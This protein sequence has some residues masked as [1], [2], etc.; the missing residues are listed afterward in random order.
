M[1]VK[2]PLVG[3]S[4]RYGHG[5]RD[6]GDEGLRSDSAL[7]DINLMIAHVLCMIKYFVL[8]G[9][10][11][12]LSLLCGH[13]AEINLLSGLLKYGNT[14]TSQAEEL[15]HPFSRPPSTAPQHSRH[16]GIYTIILAEVWKIIIGCQLHA[17][18]LLSRL[19]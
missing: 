8:H 10:F 1:G 6:H 11:M 14:F 13:F 17:S 16:I 7:N 5:R 4:K 9:L 15:V 12:V 18:S 19:G 2:S 3:Q